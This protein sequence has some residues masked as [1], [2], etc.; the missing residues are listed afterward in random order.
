M[1]RIRT[2]CFPVT[3]TTAW[4]KNP[5]FVSQSRPK[6]SMNVTGQHPDVSLKTSSGFTLTDVETQCWTVVWRRH[7]PDTNVSSYTRCRMFTEWSG[8]VQSERVSG[9]QKL[10]WHFIP[11]ASVF[12][13]RSLSSR[14]PRL[15]FQSITSF[16]RLS[17]S[18]SCC[19]SG[20]LSESGES[21]VVGSD[22]FLGLF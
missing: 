21:S 13:T 11:V 9:L 10:N 19:P 4:E 18:S 7:H 20:P 14:L 8:Y 17:L 22:D 1:F 6:I 3:R 15:R 2:C 12:C 5:V 16:M